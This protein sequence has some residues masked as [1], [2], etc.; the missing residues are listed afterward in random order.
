MPLTLL[1]L[2]ALTACAGCN[3]EEHD[4]ESPFDIPRTALDWNTPMEATN[5]FLS[6]F[7]NRI[8]FVGR[9]T[10][11]NR[12]ARPFA[13]YSFSR[14]SQKVR[15]ESVFT[16]RQATWKPGTTKVT[17]VSNSAFADLYEYDLETKRAIKKTG[18]GTTF[19]INGD[20]DEDW[21]HWFPTGDSVL[22]TIDGYEEDG[23]PSGAYVRDWEKDVP[24]FRSNLV[25]PCLLTPTIWIGT[26][27]ARYTTNGFHQIVKYNTET[28][29]IDEI[30]SFK[31]EE[32]LKY[33]EGLPSGLQISPDLTK[34]HFRFGRDIWLMNMDGTNLKRITNLKEDGLQSHIWNNTN[35]EILF[36]VFN[37]KTS[38]I[39]AFVYNLNTQKIER[40][41]K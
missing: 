31:K 13:L 15:Y 22:Y 21:V 29:R 23:W 30:T 38:F 37:P 25:H 5:I 26:Q 4:A 1:A 20:Y 32:I 19:D 27:Y 17:A 28:G 24:V 34:I 41:I 2:L 36:T 11:P 16:W 12:F 39:A 35:D 40:L 9:D 33:T 10:A 14:D 7:E 18:P 3:E 6:P 8:Y